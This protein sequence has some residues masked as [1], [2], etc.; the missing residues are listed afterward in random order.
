MDLSDLELPT[1]TGK[2]SVFRR[3]NGQVEPV[4]IDAAKPAH[5]ELAAKSGHVW[6]VGRHVGP[7]G[8][9]IL[10]TSGRTSL[11]STNGGAIIE[12]Q[13]NLNVGLLRQKLKAISPIDEVL[14]PLQTL[15]FSDPSKQALWAICER[16]GGAELSRTMQFDIG[17]AVVTARTGAGSI[18]LCGVPDGAALGMMVAD[19]IEGE[20]PIAYTLADPDEAGEGIAVAPRELVGAQ[21]TDG[22]SATWI[23]ST[24]GWPLGCPPQAGFDE[25]SKFATLAR[26][27]HDWADGQPD[28]TIQ[29][30]DLEGKKLLDGRYQDEQTI[31][32]VA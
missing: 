15:D 22:N 20:R 11:A 1:N 23:L 10:K 5:S 16:L 18:E 31:T 14:A 30:I 29:I 28:A 3:R 4:D 27:L 19:A 24:E 32:L 8:T 13:G 2:V 25:L 12:A 26:A 6:D 17:G 21:Q 7:A 9:V